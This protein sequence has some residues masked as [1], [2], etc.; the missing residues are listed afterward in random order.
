MKDSMQAV[1]VLELEAVDGGGI[2]GDIGWWMAKALKLSGA[3]M[4][5]SDPDW[6][7]HNMMG[8]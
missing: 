8:N 3:I 1:D 6:I 7:Q 5:D 4:A 2:F